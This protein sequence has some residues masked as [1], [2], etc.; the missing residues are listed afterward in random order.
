[1]KKPGTRIVGGQTTEVN[2]Y[3]W[4]AGVFVLSKITH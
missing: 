2:E 3:P 1:M 4:M